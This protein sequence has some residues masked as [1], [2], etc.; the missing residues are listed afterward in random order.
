MKNAIGVFLLSAAVIVAGW[1]WLGWPVAMPSA[2][3][4][5]GEKLECVS[6]AP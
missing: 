4:A 3:L 5:A 1:W 2:P 6:Y